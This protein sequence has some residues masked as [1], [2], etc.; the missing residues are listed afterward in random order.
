MPRKLR[1]YL[2]D[3]PQHVIQ[4]GVDR[5]S[6]FFSDDDCL[7]YLALLQ[8]YTVKHGIALHAYCLMTNHVHLLLSS[9]NAGAVGKLM[10]DIGRRY[11]Q[12]I[13]KTYKRCGTLWQGRYKASFVQTQGYLLKCMR[14]IELNP[15][16]ANMVEAPAEY[17]FSSYACNA[18]GKV[19]PLITPHL[20]YLQLGTTPTEQ[21]THYRH[22][23]IHE[24][25]DPELMLIR[26]ATQQGV[27][28]GDNR[29]SDMISQR[30]GFNV[31]P[32]SQ[33]RPKKPSQQDQP[34]IE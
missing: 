25:D 30:V 33:G 6:T 27:V 15:V 29:F 34:E 17:R 28:V 26:T 32:R 20:E 13:N 23:F 10:Q 24:L 11:V 9:P 18:L 1:L 16:R 12:Y 22:L 31:A 5:M 4:R 7:F 21:Y 19:N 3:V 2:P 8:E 14:Y